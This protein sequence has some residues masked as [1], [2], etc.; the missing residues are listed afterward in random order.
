[1]EATVS[2]PTCLLLIANSFA[3]LFFVITALIVP[4]G[5]AFDSWSAV[6]MWAVQVRPGGGEEPSTG[7]VKERLALAMEE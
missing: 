5:C 3:A 4:L 2:K 1:M 7:L 6:S